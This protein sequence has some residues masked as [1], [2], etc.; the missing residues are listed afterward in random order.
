MEGLTETIPA[1]FRLMTNKEV[2][3]PSFSVTSA[4]PSV[5]NGGKDFSVWS[6]RDDLLYQTLRAP[7]EAILGRDGVGLA[8]CAIA[9]SIATVC[10]LPVILLSIL[11][12]IRAI[13]SRR[14]FSSSNFVS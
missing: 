10:P 14:R 1:V 2:S 5:M 12:L 9:E 8:D 11:D 3:L 13:I 4:L 6:K 7:V